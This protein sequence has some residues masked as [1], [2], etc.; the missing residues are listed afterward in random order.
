[1]IRIL[2]VDD[3]AILRAG[4]KHLLSES[5]DIVVAGEAANGVDALAL[6]RSGAWDAMVL[7]MT[8]PGKSGIELIK[9]I[10]AE[11]AKLPVLVLSM[12]AE[13][14]YAVRALR[15]GASGYLCK[16]NAES[17]L[18]QAI[19]KVA[20]GGL[21]INPAVAE[22]LAV[23]VLGTAGN[24]T[25]VL[26][27]TRLSDREYEVLRHIAA[28]LGVTEIGRLLNLSVKTV[29]TYKAHAMQKM[30]FA[31]TAELIQYALKHDLVD[32]TR[33]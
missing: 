25:E 30:G 23:E 5:A 33:D 22:K 11:N 28:G 27:H 19:R 10:K 24:T 16:D 26:P 2:I 17:Q 6:A 12:H 13:D 20:A 1:M 3:H 18:E 14:I 31:N 21:Y 29:S 8:M 7:D 15:A 9:Q 4:L 32:Q